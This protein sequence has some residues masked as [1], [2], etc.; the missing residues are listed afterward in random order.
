MSHDITHERMVPLCYFDLRSKTAIISLPPHLHFPSS[1]SSLSFHT[2]VCLDYPRTTGRL[3][4]STP[5]SRS[6]RITPTFPSLPR[7]RRRILF[8]FYSESGNGFET[9]FTNSLVLVVA[10]ATKRE[11][12]TLCLSDCPL[13]PLVWVCPCHHGED[14]LTAIL[15]LFFSLSAFSTVLVWCSMEPR[16]RGRKEN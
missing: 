11:F 7:K 5:V 1:T 10:I 4:Y 15:F 14:Y 3:T 9:F 13:T 8:S 12:T 2:W 16:D 6:T